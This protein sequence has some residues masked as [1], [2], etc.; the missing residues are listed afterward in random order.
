[1]IDTMVSLPVIRRAIFIFCFGTYGK[2]S[3]VWQQPLFNKEKRL[4]SITL[5]LHHFF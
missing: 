1:M 4:F 3:M 2:S 5:R